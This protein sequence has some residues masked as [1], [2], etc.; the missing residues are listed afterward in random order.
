MVTEKNDNLVRV[1][2]VG[3]ETRC[4]FRSIYKIVKVDRSVK[5]VVAYAGS[6]ILA[7]VRARV[8]RDKA[9]NRTVEAKIVHVLSAMGTAVYYKIEKEAE[10]D[11]VS[12]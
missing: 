1:V 6:A 11:T 10:V 9:V 4:D 3:A 12:V 5:V 8:F 7:V 2:K